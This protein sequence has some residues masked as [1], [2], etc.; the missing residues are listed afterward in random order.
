MK[1][2]IKKALLT[3]MAVPLLSLGAGSA[4]LVTNAA[5][6]GG[7]QDGATPNSGSNPDLVTNGD[8]GNGACTVKGGSQNTSFVDTIKTVVNI[9]LFIIGL[10]AVVMLVIGGIRYAT[11]GG[12]QDA[13]KGAKDTILYAIIGIVVAVMA[14]AVVGFVTQNISKGGDNGTTD[15]T[16]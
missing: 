9:M 12:S 5:A 11:S 16:Q 2:I 4:V 7:C 6:A 15:L 1:Q 3:L 13:V 14:Y 10:I 8:P